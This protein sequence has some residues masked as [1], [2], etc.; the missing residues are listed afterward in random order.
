MIKTKHLWIPHF[1]KILL[2]GMFNKK[3]CGQSQ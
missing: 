1:L 2:L 3:F